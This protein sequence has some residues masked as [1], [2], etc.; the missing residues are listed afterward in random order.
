MANITPKQL[1][2]HCECQCGS[3]ECATDT[4]FIT[5]KDL[6]GWGATKHNNKCYSIVYHLDK[7][8]DCDE[9]EREREMEY[10]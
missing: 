7:C 10:N 5:H 9:G 4:R 6:K 2:I 8:S 1:A 3:A